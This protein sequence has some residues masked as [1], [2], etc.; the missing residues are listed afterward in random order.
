[1]Y[2]NCLFICQVTHGIT[3]I[4]QYTLQARR[5]AIYQ[6]EYVE[7]RFFYLFEILFRIIL[8]R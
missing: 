8:K 3:I 2:V 6:L 7:L 1:M 5:S 4:N